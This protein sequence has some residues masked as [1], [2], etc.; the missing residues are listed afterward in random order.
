MR[1]GKSG[2]RSFRAQHHSALWLHAGIGT[3][4]S[5]DHKSDW[6]HHIDGSRAQGPAPGA[7]GGAGA[8][9]AIW[10]DGGAG[11][12]RET[13]RR[14]GA[15]DVCLPP[16]IAA[17][18][19]AQPRAAGPSPAGDQKQQHLDASGNCLT[20]VLSFSKLRERLL[21]R[22]SCLQQL[23]VDDVKI[24]LATF[25]HIFVALAVIGGSLCSVGAVPADAQYYW[26]HHRYSHRHPYYYHHHR[27]YRYY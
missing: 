21:L 26:H 24:S 8:L 25:R 13:P 19:S 14:S 4:P 15:R 9:R 22:G 23:N 18:Q 27:Y 5:A 6:N 3:L 11:L 20:L 2:G 17:P 10:E 7:A 16:H 1:D 12:R